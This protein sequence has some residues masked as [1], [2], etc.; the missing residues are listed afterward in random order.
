MTES[1]TIKTDI[2]IVGAGPTGL[3][4]ANLL[5]A[6]GVTTTIV[7]TH[8]D[9]VQDPRAVSID[10]EAMRALQA[11]GLASEVAAI[12]VQGYGSIYRGPSGKVFA[13][14]MP[15]GKDYGFDKRNAFEQPAFEALLRMGL[16]RYPQVTANFRTEMTAFTQSS[17]GVRAT[18][19]FQGPPERQLCARYMIACDGGR[20][21]VRKALGIAM[22]GT[23][24]AEPW[25]IVDLKAT[26]NRCFH[27]EVFC[28][29]ARPCIT[30][31]G[32][33]G[34]RRYEFKLHPG[35]ADGLAKQDDFIRGLLAAVGPDRHQ[36]FRRVRVYTFHARIAER[37]RQG[38]VFLAGDA[39]HLTPPFAGQGLNSGLR[40]A[41]NLAWK[42]AEALGQD[43]PEYLLASYETE[44]KP[45]AWS[46][47]RLA[48]RMGGV[49]MPTSSVQGMGIRGVFRLL[50]L[51]PVAR[52][53]VMQMKYKPK[54]RFETGLIWHDGR[55][56]K[57][58]VIGQMLPQPV[59]EAVDRSTCLLDEVLPD[60]PVL[61]ILSK[62]PDVALAP[63]LQH[64][65]EALGIAVFGVTPHSMNPVAAPFPMFRDKSRG[66]SNPPYAAYVEYGLIIRRDRYI[67]AARPVALLEGLLEIG[68]HLSSGHALPP[69]I[70]A[71][72]AAKG[73]GQHQAVAKTA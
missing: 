20:S 27:T 9:T 71:T 63:E 19:R 36:A 25:L 39:A 46:L 17:D 3:L 57:T 29:P 61:L 54:P 15:T 51:S 73:A 65:F 21:P 59:V 68:Q 42:L 23:T 14:V 41:H 55:A 38:R 6:M 43:Y 13:C 31:P 58:S 49:M 26:H 47:I 24:F 48:L 16:G 22:Q 5:G 33:G 64:R 34:I 72:T 69:T 30:L 52:D 8:G 53:Y 44:R 4:L 40:D 2:L 11:A 37:W 35:E 18:V 62:Q 66:L 28:D 60:Q 12:S 45:H 50:R 7:E 10:D 32:P 1:D 67:A 70:R 56:R